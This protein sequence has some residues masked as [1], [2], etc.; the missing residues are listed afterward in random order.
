MVTDMNGS[1]KLLIFRLVGEMYGIMINDV[2]EIIEY[3]KTLI[4]P[5]QPEYI[6][7]VISLRGLI[8]PIMNLRKRFDLP[9][10]EYNTNTSIVILKYEDLDVG[11]IVDIVDEVIS[12]PV[13]KLTSPPRFNI[14]FK[15]KMVLG[16]CNFDDEIIIIINTHEVIKSSGINDM[17]I[18]LTI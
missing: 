3:R 15:N 14:D 17:N 9:P 4:I 18:P 7:G 10:Q 13:E 16:L 1:D 2:K 12:L 5:K 8:I 11:L 6:E